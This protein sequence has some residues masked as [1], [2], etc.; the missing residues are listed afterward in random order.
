MAEVERKQSVQDILKDMRGLDGLKRLFWQELNYERENKPLSTRQWPESAKS[1]LAEDPVLLA[2][3]GEEN[4]FHVVYCRLASPELKRGC[5]RPIVDQLLRDHPYALFVFSNKAQ[6]AWHFLN[7]KYDE[8][9]EKRRLV[10][11]I[12]VRPGE[13]LRTAAERLA[14][15]D[16]R[17]ISP[18]LFGLS[19]LLIQQYH[20]DAFDVEKVTKDFYREIANW[21]FWARELA[22][23]PKDAPTDADGKPSLPLIRLLTR[24]IFCWFLKGKRN[25]QTGLGL[26]PDALFEPRQIRDLLKD[27]SPE[28]CSYYTAILQNLFFATLSTE[29]DKPGCEPSRRFVTANDRDDSDDHMVP[30]YWRNEKQLRDPVVLEVVLRQ[31][32]FLNGGLFECLDEPILDDKGKKIGEIRMDGFS[33]KPHKQPRL[34]N[35]LFFGTPQAVDLS[36]AYGDSAR[37]SETVRPLLEI[38]NRYNF[39]LTEN[40][41]FDQEVALDPELLGHV[42]EN[43]L[44]AFNPETGMVARKATGSFYTPRV[45]VD[46]MVDQALLVYLKE[47]LASKNTKDTEQKLKR[48]LAWD[49]DGHDFAPAEVDRLIDAIDRMK[50]LDPA[51]GSGAF[52]MGMLQKL[53]HVLKKLDPKN[54]GWRRRQETAAEAIESGIAR[55]EALKAIRRA[56]ARDNDDYGRK[57]YLIEN[58]LYGV[59]IQPIA[60]QIAKLRFFISL[61]CDQAIDPDEENYGILPLPNLE[62]KVV[63]ANTLLG[64]HRGQLMLGSNEVKRLET[65][66]Q[67]V[68]HDYFTARSYK[69]KKVLRKEDRRLCDE[70]SKALES[71]GE[72][73][74]YDSKRLAGWN[75][76]D[77]NASASFFDPGW[78]FGL[79]APSTLESGVFNIVIGNPPYVRQEELKNQTV[80]GSDGKDKPLKDALKGQYECFTGTADLYVYFFERSFQLLRVGGLLSFITS[81]KYFR[82]AYGERLRTYLAHATQA[83][84]ILDFGDAPVFTAVA[85]PAIIV[86]RKTRSV[87]LGQLPKKV[88]AQD[89]QSR[90]MTWTPGPDIREFPDIFERD[91]FAL[92]QNDLKTDG[93]RMESPVGLRLLDRL[94]M[95]GTPL[96]KFVKNRLYRG[97]TTGFN[98][99]FVV[100]T[101]EYD[102]LIRDHRSSKELLK[103][104]ARGRDVKRWVLNDPHLWLIFTRRGCDIRKYPA[105]QKHLQTFRERLTP[106]IPGGRKPGPYEWF[107]IQDNIAY[108][109]EFQ[110]PKIVMGRFMD[111]PTYAFDDKGFFHN[112][113]LYFAADVKPYIVAVLNSPCTWFFLRKTCT[114]LQNDF[115]QALLQYQKEIPIPHTTVVQQRLCEVL[116]MALIWLH[117]PELKKVS[118]A[119]ASLMIAYLEQWLNGLVYELFFP[120]ELHA[121]R[122]TLLD[123]TAKLKPPDLSAFCDADKLN[124][125]Q[126]L[127]EKAY[128]TNSSLRGMLFDL[129]ALDVVRVIEDAGNETSNH[130]EERKQ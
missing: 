74:P 20:D 78:M 64:L 129:R 57:L 55:E 30:Q 101:E 73:T 84:A 49:E 116:T 29:M 105:I 122:L 23:F 87:A 86:T 89:W 6:T 103:P 2:S 82:A 130:T 106:G 39:T 77:T 125:L 61:V 58:C 63:A 62:T 10:R 9:A 88:E 3:G 118:D 85:Y 7:V 91:G 66:L 93:W 56:F 18:E 97:I 31:I 33:V 1:A 83:H 43:L 32:P 107:E 99:A 128:N 111:K 100:N 45:V 27:A 54:Q 81:N 59:D 44:A 17:G 123:E 14:L 92:A 46:W 8:Q 104:Y 124:V 112:D 108:W 96:G 70:L 37:Q 16:L 119:S 117:S 28:S 21:Y 69:R 60:V 12:A 4:A 36:N 42:F 34:P 50:A 11:R 40:T 67:K 71:S 109:E 95:A 75:P 13:G 5:Q 126:E 35:S 110:T 79:P 76:Y 102:Q 52:P 25:P 53:A 121:R 15:L 115:L 127:H 113:A 38:L 24:M 68:R 114:D 120:G 72:C 94:C 22:V 48:L 19:P 41:P 26:L 98:D 65:E 90:V 47:S 51:C 80:K